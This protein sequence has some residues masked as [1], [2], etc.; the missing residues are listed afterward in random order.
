MFT[1]IGGKLTIPSSML[2]REKI[3]ALG[4]DPT[5]TDTGKTLRKSTA[6]Q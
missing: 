3:G 6:F 5:E 1:C 2:E 4:A